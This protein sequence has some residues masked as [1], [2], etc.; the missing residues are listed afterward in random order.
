[1]YIPHVPIPTYLKG[2][3]LWYE[4]YVYLCGIHSI[5]P[6]PLYPLMVC[7]N[8]V[9]PLEGWTSPNRYPVPYQRDVYLSDT[10]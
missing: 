10:L 1:M 2:S 7:T 6:L 4:G 5:A 9:V 8:G 3:H